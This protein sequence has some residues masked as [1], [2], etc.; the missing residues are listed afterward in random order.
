MK[1]QI[2]QGRMVSLCIICS[3][4]QCFLFRHTRKVDFYAV[5]QIEQ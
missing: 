5:R 1:A 4:I 3:R 2:H